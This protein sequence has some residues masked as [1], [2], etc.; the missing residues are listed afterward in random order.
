MKKTKVVQPALPLVLE[1]G[2]S[3]PSAFSP[4]EATFDDPLPAKVSPHGTVGCQTKI[5][6]V[7]Q[8][9]TDDD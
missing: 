6:K 9:T 5:T 4:S 1:L 3:Q 7:D 2:V 8:E